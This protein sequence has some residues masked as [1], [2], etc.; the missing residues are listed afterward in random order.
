LL[1]FLLL[2][3][4]AGA[5]PA[6]T[7]QSSAAAKFNDPTACAACHPRQYEE[8]QGAMMAYASVSPVFNALEAAGNRLTA[9]AFAADGIAP[10]FCQRCHSP[11]SVALN[12]FPPYGATGGRPSRDFTGSI[13]SHGLSCDF[14]H[15]IAHA[16]VAGSLL[17]D[18]IAN[19]ALVIQ[20]GVFKFG[21][22]T[23]PLSNSFHQAT[24][25]DYLRSAQFC[26]GCHDVRPQGEDVITGEPFRRLENAFTE[27]QQG[28]Y[29]TADNPYGRVVT[30]QDC[31]MSAYPYAPPGTYFQDRA[32]SLPAM[33]LRQVST[34]YFTGVDI[35]LIDFPGQDDPSL[36]SHN[37]PIG[38][39][40]RRADLLRKACTLEVDVP[41]TIAPGSTLPITVA[42]TNSGAG[43]NVPSGFSQERQLWIEL[44]VSDATDQVLYQSGYLVDQPHPETG[45]DLP[46]GNL[47]DE[48]LQDLTG[49]VD[50]ITL[51][52]DVGPGPDA[53]LRPAANLGLVNFG[54]QFKLITASGESEVFVP[55]LANHMDNSHSIPPLQTA[56]A[57]YD[58]PLPDPLVGPLRV[59]VRLR[60]RPFPPRFLRLMAQ[61]RPDLVDEGIVDRNQIVDMAETERLVAVAS[62]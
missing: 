7:G 9:G 28:P 24:P 17:G 14:C 20:P 32:T 44:T 26:G 54:N 56:R 49:S 31:H 12:E 8:W 10:L 3:G 15:Q 1:A 21:P 23:Q 55:F 51:E 18:G 22:F 53:D 13:G 38:Q 41:D 57:P 46:D 16:D 58:V 43:H 4:C 62:P 30:C 2:Q 25:S 48:D 42:V 6:D 52:A 11:I 50:P 61:A 35:A 33:P 27:W 59:S 39:M 60:F 29:S 36:D 40:Q 5:G 47:A 45:E 34:H 19:A 37:V